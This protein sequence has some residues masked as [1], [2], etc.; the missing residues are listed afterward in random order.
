M[1]NQF[2]GYQNMTP[3]EI[4]LVELKALLEGFNE[5]ATNDVQ[6]KLIIYI[7]HCHKM[8]IRKFSEKIP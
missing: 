2:G 7:N 5:L 6:K 8:L 3:E 1:N 4:S